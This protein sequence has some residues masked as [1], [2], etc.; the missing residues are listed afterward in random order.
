M[1]TIRCQ[2]SNL[3][4][5]IHLPWTS[6]FFSERS[7]SRY[8]RTDGWAQK[9]WSLLGSRAKALC[10]LFCPSWQMWVVTQATGQSSLFLFLVEDS[11]GL[12]KA[13]F[14]VRTRNFQAN[15]LQFSW[16]VKALQVSFRTSY[17]SSVLKSGLIRI[18]HL[19]QSATLFACLCACCVY[20]R[21]Y[22]WAKISLPCFTSSLYGTATC[23]WAMSYQKRTL[24]H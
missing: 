17:A 3:P 6:C 18:S 9:Q 24:Q 20:Q 16:Q 13:V 22:T 8:L 2:I 12:F 10:S 19:P 4:V 7:S 5:H 14:I 23:R 11:L 1:N 21:R 15:T